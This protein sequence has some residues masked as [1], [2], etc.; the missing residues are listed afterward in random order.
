MVFSS[1]FITEAELDMIKAFSQLFPL[2]TFT[3]HDRSEIFQYYG[4][5]WFEKRTA[6]LGY[7][8]LLFDYG[9]A[10]NLLEKFHHI[11][12]HLP[13]STAHDLYQVVWQIKKLSRNK[14][15]IMNAFPPKWTDALS[16]G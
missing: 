6:S 8:P 15:R 9:D 7:L 10:Q 11:T 5:H 16:L 2:L 1:Q 4:D 12:E 13:Q 14:S 3:C